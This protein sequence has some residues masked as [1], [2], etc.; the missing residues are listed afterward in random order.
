MVP[1]RCLAAQLGQRWN[2]SVWQRVARLLTDGPPDASAPSTAL[3]PR[4]R[5]IRL[6]KDQIDRLCTAY[7]AG[8]SVAELSREHRINVKTA[9]KHLAD[10]GIK[11]RTATV[12][13]TAADYSTLLHL[14]SIGWNNVQI[15]KYYGAT[16]QAVQQ[17]LRR[18]Q[19]HA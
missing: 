15:A 7:L 13:L 14:K 8:Q 6:T 10:R 3:K 18:A 19:P 5:Q 16:R 11:I 2:F 17:A 9:T 12:N 4:Q 1:P